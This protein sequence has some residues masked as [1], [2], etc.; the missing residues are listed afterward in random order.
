MFAIRRTKRWTVEKSYIA[1]EH[2]LEGELVPNVILKNETARIQI[3]LTPYRLIYEPGIPDDNNVRVDIQFA[4]T[5]PSDLISVLES[6]LANESWLKKTA[7]KR[8][9]IFGIRDKK[10]ENYL[11]NIEDYLLKNTELNNTFLMRGFNQLRDF[12]NLPKRVDYLPLA[13]DDAIDDEALADSVFGEGY[14]F[15]RR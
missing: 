7:N 11:S 15:H 3:G 2:G 1:F 5:I 10:L 9:F 13:E 8:S 6:D 14:R 4:K 12:M